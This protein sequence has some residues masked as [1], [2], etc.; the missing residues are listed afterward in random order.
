MNRNVSISERQGS[1]VHK[2]F[3]RMKNS[4][5]VLEKRSNCIQTKGKKHE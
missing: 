1:Q 3:S 5:F 4:F 2:V